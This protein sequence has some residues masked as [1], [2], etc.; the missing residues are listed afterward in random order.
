MIRPNPKL[1]LLSVL[2]TPV[3][4]PA[5][6]TSEPP[7]PSAKDAA[8]EEPIQLPAF[9]IASEKDVA[10]VGKSALSS[11]RIAV[12]L[13]ELP[14]S[15]KVLNNSFLTA[16]N[17]TMMTD[18]L[19]YVGGGQNGNLNWTPGRMNVRG[20]TGDADYMDGFA[21]PQG[22]VV[23]SIIYD[24]FEVIK[25]PSTIF[26]AADGSPGGVVNK[27]TKSPLAQHSTTLTLQ[28]GRFEGNKVGFDTTGPVTADK[29][30][31]YR[32]VGG[33]T[34]Y[35][36]YY[37]Y[38]YMRR[39]TVV[40]ELSYQFNKDTKLELKSEFV[41]TNW[42]SYNGLPVDPRTGKMFDLPYDST[43]DEDT[44]YNWRHDNVNRVWGSFNTRP[45]DWLAISV[46]G[47]KA[48]DRAD[49][50]ES[51]T[52]PWNEGA[53]TWASASVTPTTYTGGPI[54]RPTTNDDAH[55][56]YQALQ[57]DLNFNYTAK[58][59]TELLLVGAERRNQP[60]R[61]VTYSGH[62]SSSPWYPYAPGTPPVIVTS[63]DPSAYT[64]QQ[65]LLERVYGLETLKLFNDRLVL[66][67]GASRAKVYGSN[68]NYLT[69]NPASF[70]PFTLYKNLVQ[71]G[72]V[73][74][75]MDGISLFT[76]YNQNFAANGV[77]TYNGVPNVPL[78]PKLGEQHEV[79][80]KF[81]LMNHAFTGNVAYFDINQ[82]NNTVPSFPLDPANPN[83]LIPGVIS[84][85]FDLDFSW[86]VDRHLY[87]IGA[88]A[89]YSAK[90]V[91]GPAVDGKFIQPGTGAV[92]H[93]SIPVNNTA[94]QT[95]SLYVLYSFDAG[96]LKNFSV[97]VGPNFQSKRAVTDGPNQVFWGY[98]P[99][100]TIVNA[101]VN[102]QYNSHLKY[103]LTIDNLLDKKYI[104][105][106][107]SE[108][109]QIPGTPIN[110]KLAVAYTF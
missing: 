83:V 69:Q 78:P 79:G 106:V 64:A 45:T 89:N 2:L 71:W 94:E 37:R 35:N 62:E 81:D 52:A 99:S 85:G 84:R 101:T 70:I 22:S 41:R 44:P 56:A 103:T 88:A 12:D 49:R 1:I 75:V 76:G 46:R 6:T 53:R 93:G 13:S 82:K 95:A 105:S 15:V 100:R 43:Q 21:P 38:T 26:L 55:T 86:K 65:S 90:S 31:L 17:P 50:L 63:T 42:P 30:L 11:T 18:V 4:L 3:L 5:Q 19:N 104:Y 7:A 51:I 8:K 110:V 66:N 61:T 47:M 102:Y 20:F 92:A 16:I 60:S 14:Q 54:P 9:T 91:L 68:F 48:T 57:T 33:E 28:V 108:N 32:L 40:P 58:H 27:I 87:L 59:F 96:T 107:R 23:D 36:G 72:V 109:V 67:F 25:G 73:I 24:R 34:Y 39:F 97:G 80:L 10:Y 29:R 77:G 98:I 74:K